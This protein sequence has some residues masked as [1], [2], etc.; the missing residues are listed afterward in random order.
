MGLHALLLLMNADVSILLVLCTIS[1][2]NV[3]IWFLLEYTI[4]LMVHIYN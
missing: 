2:L 4:S 3:S 1:V